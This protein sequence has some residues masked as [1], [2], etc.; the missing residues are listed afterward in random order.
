MVNTGIKF[1]FPC[2]EIVYLFNYLLLGK[3]KAFKVTFELIK[4]IIEP[5]YEKM[6]VNWLWIFYSRDFFMTQQK[7]KKQEIY[8]CR[9]AQKVSACCSDRFR[10]YKYCGVVTASALGFHIN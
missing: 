3:Y 1:S 7:N 9:E 4:T 5:G 8:F 2:S 6:D 10:R